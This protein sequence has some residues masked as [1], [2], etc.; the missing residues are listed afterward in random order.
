MDAVPYLAEDTDGLGLGKASSGVEDL[1]QVDAFAQLQREL[2]G[3]VVTDERLQQAGD[4]GVGDPGEEVEL[5]CNV[6]V[7]LNDVGA[8]AAPQRGDV[9][10]VAARQ[11]RHRLAVV[12]LTQ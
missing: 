7:E 1:L 8:G 6:L 10:Q 5:A 2:D 4:R 3:A 12:E 11:P 9:D